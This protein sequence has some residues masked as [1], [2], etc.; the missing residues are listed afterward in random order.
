MLSLFI[1][2][3]QLFNFSSASNQA[4]KHLHNKHGSRAKFII[5][6]V[7]TSKW[8]RYSVLKWQRPWWVIVLHFYC[9]FVLF[10]YGCYESTLLHGTKCSMSWHFSVYKS[11]SLPPLSMYRFPY[12]ITVQ[13]ISLDVISQQRKMEV[14]RR[15]GTYWLGELVSENGLRIW[16]RTVLASGAASTR[17]LRL[18]LACSE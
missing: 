13:Q 15:R 6:Y 10:G 12:V 7:F 2:M 1:Q 4:T 3:I 8:L 11:W 5:N 16:G 17:A 18:T 9:T 14:Q